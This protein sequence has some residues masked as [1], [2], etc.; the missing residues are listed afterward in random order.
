MTSRILQYNENFRVINE[1]RA[2]L[3]ALMGSAGSGKSVNV[4]Q[5]LFEHLIQNEGANLLCVRKAEVT[6]RD[7]TFAEFVQI[8][9]KLDLSDNIMKC[10]ENPLRVTFFNGN[11]ILFRGAMNQKEREKLKSIQVRKGKLTD[12]WVE[13][14]TEL[15]Q[16]DIEILED[17]LRGELPNG[18]RYRMIL[19]FNPV[20][21]QHWIK[22]AY[23]DQQHDD[24][25]THHS[26]Y[27]QNAFVDE[28]YH[29][30]MER[31]KKLDPLGYQIYGLIA[32]SYKT[33]L[34]RWNSKRIMA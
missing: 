31:R 29:K 32:S 16:E 9:T 4:A 12:I 18:L 21:A 30:R 17:R 5:L 8:K 34:K 10:T 2:R 23:F 19:T 24:V 15:T 1:S 27:L 22:E 11:S 6:N 13:E 33:N 14:A 20:S 3:L 25:Q 26:T 7:S 28:G